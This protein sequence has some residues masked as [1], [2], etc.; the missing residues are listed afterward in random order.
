ML[1]NFFAHYSFS[2]PISNLWVQ[3]L[4]S[5]KAPFCS[6]LP[7]HL[8]KY[9]F[10][11]IFDFYGNWVWNCS[12]HWMNFRVYYCEDA[13]LINW[14]L[15]LLMKICWLF[16]CWSFVSNH[17]PLAAFNISSLS[18]GFCNFTVVCLDMDLFLYLPFEGV[19]S[20][21]C[22]ISFIKNLEGS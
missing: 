15:L 14:L 13:P 7:L 6:I 3:F 5:W 8:W 9:Y 21:M 4:S 17:F 22:V 19:I 20:W 11:F 16:K 18:F 2:H 12:W 1:I 10:I